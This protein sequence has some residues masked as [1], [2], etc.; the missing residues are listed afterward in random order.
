MVHAAV[1]VAAAALPGARLD[2][3]LNPVTCIGLL[4]RVPAYA[5]HAGDGQVD[6][7]IVPDQV[8]TGSAVAFL[9]PKLRRRRGTASASVGAISVLLFPMLTA[10][11]LEHPHVDWGVVLLAFEV[12]PALACWQWRA[13]AIGWAGGLAGRWAQ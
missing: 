10:G 4:Y 2:N 3:E 6:T 5:D 7:A 9:N 13:N 11:M 12:V 1:V 8:T